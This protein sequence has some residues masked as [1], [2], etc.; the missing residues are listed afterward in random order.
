M[1]AFLSVA[2][3]AA[4]ILTAAPASAVVIGFDD[5][6]STVSLANIPQGYGGLNWNNFGVVH[7]DRNPNTGYDT[8]AISGDYPAYNNM[9]LP[10]DITAITDTFSFDG[11]WFTSAWEDDNILLIEGFTDDDGIADYSLSL[12]L[13]TQTPLFLDVHWTGLHRLRFTTSGLGNTHFAMDDLRI[14]EGPMTEVPEPLTI[15]LLG[16]GLLGVAGA[17]RR[18]R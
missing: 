2:A 1:K 7:K 9:A 11:A 12:T 4:S 6:I 14:N 10:A 5:I 17:R 3:V 13:N 8:G 18:R 15:G 16:M